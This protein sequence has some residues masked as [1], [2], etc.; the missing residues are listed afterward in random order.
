MLY[1]LVV[2]HQ[3][4]TAR[5][6]LEAAALGDADEGVEDG[7]DGALEVLEDAAEL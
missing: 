5:L 1:W 2:S 6:E 7:D 3:P 4:V